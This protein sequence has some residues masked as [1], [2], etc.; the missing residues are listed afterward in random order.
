MKTRE[1]IE[2]QAIRC[3]R[4]FNEISGE[5]ERSIDKGQVYLLGNMLLWILD[6]T[7]Y[8]PLDAYD[9]LEVE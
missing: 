1:Q 3:N 7:A 8:N 4:I 5:P 9:I 6:D 2:E